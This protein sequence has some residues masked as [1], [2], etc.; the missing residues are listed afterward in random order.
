[1]NKYLKKFF[2]QALINEQVI[3]NENF[4]R[5]EKGQESFE[6]II[7]QL[8]TVIKYRQKNPKI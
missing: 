7:T 1:M 5:V 3:M 2:R 6:K 8:F 4:N